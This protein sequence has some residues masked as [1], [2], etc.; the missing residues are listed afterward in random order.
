MQW[1]KFLPVQRRAP[2]QNK[3]KGTVDCH[4]IDNTKLLLTATEEK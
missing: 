1:V 2:A 3:N 4:G